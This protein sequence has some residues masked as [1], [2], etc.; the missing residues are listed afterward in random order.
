MWKFKAPPICSSPFACSWEW[1]SWKSG[2]VNVKPIV[3]YLRNYIKYIIPSK[4]LFISDV[5]MLLFS[6]RISKKIFHKY[7]KLKIFSLGSL[8]LT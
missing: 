8:E 1:S 3:I 7:N 5:S 2:P 4:T 6:E